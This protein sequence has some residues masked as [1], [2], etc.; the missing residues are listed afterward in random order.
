M[1]GFDWNVFVGGSA[2]VVT[3]LLVL[4]GLSRRKARRGAASDGLPAVREPK[5]RIDL[6]TI[7]EGF[8]AEAAEE[9]TRT[10]KHVPI[11]DERSFHV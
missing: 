3:A 10:E 2:A 8:A 5:R 4:V 11:R 7:D 1:D 6:V 9:E